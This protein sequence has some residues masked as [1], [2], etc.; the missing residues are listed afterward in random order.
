[1]GGCRFFLHALAG[2]LPAT[3]ALAS[4]R[5]QTVQ[6]FNRDSTPVNGLMN[7]FFSHSITDADVHEEAQF[8]VNG[9]ILHK[10]E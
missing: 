3:A 2:P 5:Q 7:L 1:M 8:M 6:V 4:H 9:F 10:W